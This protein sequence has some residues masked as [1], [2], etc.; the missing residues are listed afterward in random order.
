MLAANM[1]AAALVVP[2]GYFLPLLGHIVQTMGLFF[3]P[4]ICIISLSRL[5]VRRIV[6]FFAVAVTASIAVDLVVFGAIDLAA[7]SLGSQSILSAS[8]LKIIQSIFWIA[9]SATVYLA[10]NE[11][12]LELP[13]RITAR[14]TFLL[15]C[16]A[17]AL[18]QACAGALIL[19]DGGS[20]GWT[21]ASYAFVGVAFLVMIGMPNPPTREVSEA[22]LVIL[23]MA[24]LLSNA[25]RS[26]Y[27]SAADINY[28]Y[29][30]ASM[31]QARVIWDPFSFHDAFME[32]LSSS[33]LP[34]I[35]SNVSGLTLLVVF[36][37]V[38]PAVF[39]LIVVLVMDLARVLVSERGAIAATFIFIVQPA[40]Q[41]WLSI[42][43]RVEVAYMLF[44]LSLW[45]LLVPRVSGESRALLFWFSSIGMVISH[46]T[47]SYIACFFYIIVLLVGRLVS[48]RAHKLSPSLNGHKA[49]SSLNRRVLNWP[50]VIIISA[51]A[52][53]WYGP[54]TA[55]SRPIIAE[56]TVQ[57]AESLPRI[58][59]SSV[60]TQGQ[61][62]LSGFGLLSTNKPKNVVGTYIKQTTNEYQAR[63]GPA[64]LLGPLSSS[65]S[66]RSVQLAAVPVQKPW[67]T[68]V[69][70]L[71][72]ASKV[73]ALLL[74]AIGAIV[75]WR[76][77][78][79][80][81]A[82]VFALSAFLSSII[83]VV[84][85]FVSVDYDLNR[86]FQQFLILMAPMMVIGAA[87]LWKRPWR[88]KSL[89]ACALIIFYFSLLSRVAFQL[90]GGPDVSMTFN[91]RGWDYEH[92]YVTGTDISTAQWLAT[93][94]GSENKKQ[95]VFADQVGLQ[96][97]RLAAP[98]DLSAEVKLDLLPSTFVKGSYLF[99]DS[100]NVSTQ[101]TARDYGNQTLSLAISFK[102][103]DGTLNRVYSTSDTAVYTGPSKLAAVSCVSDVLGRPGGPAGSRCPGA[104][105]RTGT[106]PR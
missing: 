28:E 73:F 82:Q 61:T 105:R 53:A 38:M 32:C 101:G 87:A 21:L 67:I 89:A 83:L 4:G 36:K 90:A 81:L 35:I 33:L 23:G 60:Q 103:F 92:Y 86:L 5:N 102:Y 97:L 100:A 79:S 10:G 17:S 93:Q 52:V 64:S 2:L 31:V 7:L 25:L 69:P 85:P 78:T 88:Y 6:Q 62:P 47:T 8:N 106:R 57:T 94:W 37:L 13:S 63:Y 75:L 66:V 11:I 12:K 71:R 46:Y 55:H 70:M 91:N 15:C 104:D 51:A 1:V 48:W 40:F 65:A 54:V 26:S 3:F 24:L 20:G 77:R 80:D 84:T 19:N 68:I 22:T 39:T 45:A 27:I 43:V 42:A 29:Q 18:V 34:V 30:I 72:S 74:I 96:R 44:A 95:L 56:Y 99:L 14:D 76:K 58:F 50:S 49:S 59:E 16:A 9:L 41:Q 98:L